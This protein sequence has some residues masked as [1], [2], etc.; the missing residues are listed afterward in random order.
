MYIFISL[1][2]YSN[3]SCVISNKVQPHRL[4]RRTAVTTCYQYTTSSS[5]PVV[6]IMVVTRIPQ[7]QIPPRSIQSYHFPPRCEASFWKKYCSMRYVHDMILLVPSIVSTQNHS[8]HHTFSSCLDCQSQR[9]F[10]LTKHAIAMILK[11]VLVLKA[12]R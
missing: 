4:T 10:I 2:I 3:V 11:R 7:V 5:G 9:R 8:I 6:A 12:S 1:F